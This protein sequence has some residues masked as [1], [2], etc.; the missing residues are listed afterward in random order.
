MALGSQL[1]ILIADRGEVC[2]HL[3]ACRV[4]YMNVEHQVRPGRPSVEVCFRCS[5]TCYRRV[6]LLFHFLKHERVP[7]TASEYDE[8]KTTANTAKAQD[9]CTTR[10]RC[11]FKAAIDPPECACECHTKSVRLLE[12]TGNCFRT[13]LHLHSI[14]R[15]QTD[16]TSTYVPPTQGTSYS[17][18]PPNH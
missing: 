12:S 6:N 18:L 3:F 13:V 14:F 16:P 17:F 1:L 11:P 5:A 15:E 7:R 8:G 9:G 4:S 2:V 10:F